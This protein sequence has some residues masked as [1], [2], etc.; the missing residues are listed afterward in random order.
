MF[1]ICVLE[2]HSAGYIT[3]SFFGVVVMSGRISAA[4]PAQSWVEWGV[5][6]RKTPQLITSHGGID[7]CL[8]LAINP[9]LFIYLF[10]SI[11]YFLREKMKEG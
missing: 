5:R 1:H 9:A 11:H 10:M 6:K 8:Q 7:A 2:V 4:L 3:G